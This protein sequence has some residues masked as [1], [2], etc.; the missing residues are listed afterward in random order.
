MKLIAIDYK[1]LDNG[2]FLKAFAESL[3]RI[4]YPEIMIVHSD[5]EYTQRVMQLGIMRDEA[6]MRSIKDLNHRL[7]TLLSDNGV[8]CIGIN[9]YQKHAATINDKGITFNE[10]VF[11]LI[12][13]GVRS[14]ISA[15]AIDINN[16]LPVLVDLSAFMI[17][18]A[19]FTGCN[20]ITVF[21]NDEKEHFFAVS[22]EENKEIEKKTNSDSLIVNSLRNELIVMR[23][24]I[25]NNTLKYFQK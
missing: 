6:Q 1:N 8:P 15:S 9:G 19:E 13:R 10:K 25:Y 17:E 11:S 16:G 21:D 22:H 7:V 23:K 18:L 2:L 4:T 24:P 3:A 20:E 12:P 14:V 5:S